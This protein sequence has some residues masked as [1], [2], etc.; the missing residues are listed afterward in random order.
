MAFPTSLL[1]DVRAD[2]LAAAVSGTLLSFVRNEQVITGLALGAADAP[3]THVLLD[4]EHGVPW[5][6]A[7]S[8]MAARTKALHLPAAGRLLLDVS[9]NEADVRQL[10]DYVGCLGMTSN[11]LVACAT[12][13]RDEWRDNI[14]TYVNLGSLSLGVPNHELMNESKWLT[15]WS[16]SYRTATDQVV[17]LLGNP[18][19]PQEA[20]LRR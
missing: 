4:G 13:G 16:L 7:V 14:Q 19:W 5:V 18:Q 15:N 12:G 10:R 8:A 20:L 6:V 11:G 3:A 17:R 2:G 9:D 1:G